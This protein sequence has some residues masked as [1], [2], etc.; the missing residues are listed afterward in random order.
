MTNLFSF[1]NRNKV[2]FII[3][4]IIAGL[5]GFSLWKKA[6]T[7]PNYITD[8]VKRDSISDIVSESGNL[9]TEGQANISSPIEGVISSILVSNGEKVSKDQPL[10]T[11]SSVAT[12]QDKAIANANLLAAQS[13]TAISHQTEITLGAALDT[14]KQQLFN[15]QNTYNTVHK[16]YRGRTTNPS[17]GKTYKYIE[18]QSAEAALAAAKENLQAAQQK[19]DDVNKSIEASQAAEASAQMTYDG[20]NNLIVKAPSA[21]TVYNLSVNIGDKVSLASGSSTSAPI[22]IITKSEKLIFKTQINEIDITKLQ[23]DQAATI[24][25]DAIKDKTFDAKIDKIDKIGTNTQGVISYNVY[26]SI[27][28]PDPN[29]RSSMSGSVDVEV[30]KH[31]NVLTVANSAIKPYQGG[32]A[33]QVEETKTVNGKTKKT[34][35]YLPVKIGLKGI[36]RTEILEGIQEGQIVILS[37][38]AKTTSSPLGGN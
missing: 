35:T 21:G 25:I 38:A 12:D 2:Y 19:Y 20:K 9:I 26:F 29:M 33:V 5:I 1:I 3:I 18:F 13:N 14:A 8:T 10:F 24:K 16:G 36:E 31:E 37:T 4:L 23:I 30:A 7:P 15:A 11:V 17:T 34:L 28:N 22:L 27:T 6:N 32:K